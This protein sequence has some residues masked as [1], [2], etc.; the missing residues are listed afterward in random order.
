MATGQQLTPVF[1]RPTFI[2]LLFFAVKA[3][4]RILGRRGKADVKYAL[5][6]ATRNLVYGNTAIKTALG[7]KD[8]ATARYTEYA[9]NGKN[10]PAG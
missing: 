9:L 1:F 2:R 7:W 10:R 6:S 3:L 5:A 8:D 4:K